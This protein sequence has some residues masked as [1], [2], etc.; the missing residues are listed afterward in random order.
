MLKD[1][2]VAVRL[3]GGGSQ[4][5]NIDVVNNTIIST[6]ARPNDAGYSVNN[7]S[8]EMDNVR[9][10]NN[11]FY[12]SLSEAMNLGEAPTF[13][14]HSFEQQRVLRL[15]RVWE[16]QRSA[17]H[18]QH[19]EGDAQPGQREPRRNQRRSAVHRHRH[20][21]AP[22]RLTG[23]YGGRGH[24]DLNGN[25]ST[26][27]IIPAGAWRHGRRADRPG[28]SAAAAGWRRADERQR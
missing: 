3:F 2:D 18:V 14:G 7:Q 21:Q 6:N 17:A 15:R 28:G 26:S 25:G 10:H 27:D 1:N 4:A 13:G 9:V 8:A 16:P 19:L 22:V 12:G 11:I 23:S 24:P 5:D 20:V